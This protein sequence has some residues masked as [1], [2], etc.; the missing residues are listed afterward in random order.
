MSPRGGTTTGSSCSVEGQSDASAEV[1][2]K[3]YDLN[4]DEGGLQV[5]EEMYLIRFVCQESVERSSDGALE[6][7]YHLEG[8]ALLAGL[9][10]DRSDDHI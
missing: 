2:V 3:V 8:A 1:C 7:L 10:R 5:E 9:R 4:L 6:A